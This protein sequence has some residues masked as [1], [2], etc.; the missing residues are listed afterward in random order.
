MGD[1]RAATKS[2]E[3]A[4]RALIETYKNVIS[5]HKE[6]IRRIATTA[7]LARDA[8][9]K[10][11]SQLRRRKKHRMGD[12]EAVGTALAAGVTLSDQL[13]KALAEFDTFESG[14]ELL[15]PLF[16][17]LDASTFVI[18]QLTTAAPVVPDDQ[19]LLRPEFAATLLVQSLAAP[20]TPLL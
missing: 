12:P 13:G 15:D 14:L 20:N 19:N 1:V 9:A 17:Q 10:I 7:R 5:A 2:L 6:R 11:S 4:R 16:G 3:R 8:W 18:R